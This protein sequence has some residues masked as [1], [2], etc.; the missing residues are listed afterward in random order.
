MRDRSNRENSAF[1]KLATNK[2]FDFTR[3]IVPLLFVFFVPSSIL[4][5]ND[6]ILRLATTTS[7]E[8]SG[9]LDD[10]IPRFEAIT[11]LRVDIIA[12]GTGRALKYGETGD[13]DCVLVH[14]RTAEDAFV[15]SGFGVN[16]KRVMHNDFIL[17]GPAEDPAG[18]RVAESASSAMNM[19]ARLGAEITLTYRSPLIVFV[20]RGDDSGTHD[21]ERELWGEES[22]PRRLP[23][24]FDAG[25]GMAQ[26]LAIAFE[27][28]AYTLTDRS[29]YSTMKDS[30]DLEILFESDPLLFNPY[31]I[32]ATNPAIHPHVNYQGAMSL[33]NWMISEEGQTWIVDFRPD[34]EQLFFP[35]AIQAK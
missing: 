21:K 12:V 29:T 6:D 32:I 24:Y 27:K 10:I 9:L 1:Q 7:T 25:Q 26:V 28:R 20:S 14:S 34:G 33:I 5:S 17:V 4:F 19:I 23:W 8:N 16:R 15:R 22:G 13:V 35:S 18:I 3:G 2:G 11:G 30:L 31:S